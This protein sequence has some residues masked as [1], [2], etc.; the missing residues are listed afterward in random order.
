METSLEGFDGTWGWDMTIRKYFNGGDADVKMLPIWGSGP[1]KALAGA[2]S[3]W[4]GVVLLCLWSG[5]YTTKFPLS[6][7]PTALACPA[8]EK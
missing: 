3:V 6:S 1:F 8:A 4:S 7:D 5:P 2:D